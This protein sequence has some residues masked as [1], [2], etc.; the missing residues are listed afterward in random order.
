V[1]SGSGRGTVAG[2]VVEVTRREV[3]DV[4]EVVVVVDEVWAAAGAGS[5]IA[6]LATAAATV[7]VPAARGRRATRHTTSKA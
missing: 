5:T 7:H 3:V 1:T 6:T 4:V 2:T